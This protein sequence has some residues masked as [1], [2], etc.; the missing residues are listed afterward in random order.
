MDDGVIRAP[1]KV[2]MPKAIVRAGLICRNDKALTRNDDAGQDRSQ[3]HAVSPRR[4]DD[5]RSARGDRPG[6]TN[7]F[8]VVQHYLARVRAYNGVASALVTLDGAPV[9]EATGVVRAG[10]PLK[11]PTQTVKASIILPD[12]DKYQGRRSVQPHGTDRLQSKGAA[13]VRHDRRHSQRRCQRHRH[14]QHRGRA[15]RHLLGR[16]RQAS[17]AWPAAA[18]GAAGVRVPSAA[19]RMERAAELDRTFGKIPI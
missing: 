7:V 17:V 1:S 8:A 6:A 4:G 11:F 16:V 5:P 3:D 12:L 2:S 10:A 15:L 19:R 9:A 18:G 14:S 13:A